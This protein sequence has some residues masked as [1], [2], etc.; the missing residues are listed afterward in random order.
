MA[1]ILKKR[2]GG[3]KKEISVCSQMGK[4]NKSRQ[5]QVTSYNNKQTNSQFYWDE[6]GS[7]PFLTLFYFFQHFALFSHLE[8]DTLVVFAAGSFIYLLFI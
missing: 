8:I 6:K 1:M 2:M 4:Q 3:W 5:Q 7:N